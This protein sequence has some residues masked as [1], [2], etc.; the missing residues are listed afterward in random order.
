MGEHKFIFWFNV[1]VGPLLGGFAA[2]FIAASVLAE[3]S[4][5]IA[6]EEHC[7]R[8]WVGA[9][10]GWAGAFAA[11]GALFGLYQQLKE[12]RRQTEFMIG[13]APP[14]I[15]VA[16]DLDNAETIVVRI[17][18]WNRRGLILNGVNVLGTGDSRIWISD[19]KLDD[20]TW[21]IRNR[22]TVTHLNGWTDRQQAPHTVQYKLEGIDK[23][24]FF[25]WPK[26]TTV[27]GFI[28]LIDE[29]PRSFAIRAELHPK[30]PI[31]G[32][33]RLRTYDDM[34]S[35]ESLNIET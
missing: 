35:V 30:E 10:S 21:D 8:D 13:D 22:G 3:Y 15:D 26:Q 6:G 34:K 2:Y 12:Q 23:N 25:V 33:R 18:N 4:W 29:R 27:E 32:G 28:Q 7:V 17:V 20:V 11:G 1:I 24:P 14:T 5:C 19:M 31:S 9:L 16:Y